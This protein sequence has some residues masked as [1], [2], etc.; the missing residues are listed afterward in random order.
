[1]TEG[2]FS[3]T[4]RIVADAAECGVGDSFR[5]VIYERGQDLFRFFVCLPCL[6][7]LVRH[8]GLGVGLGSFLLG[9]GV[10]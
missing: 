10:G 1:M 3:H 4:I 6:P 8:G 2:T 7:P 5:G 9:L